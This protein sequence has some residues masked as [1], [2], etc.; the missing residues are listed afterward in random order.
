MLNLKPAVCTRPV[1]NENKYEYIQ[2][3]S[4]HKML[5]PQQVLLS[6]RITKMLPHMERAWKGDKKVWQYDG[7]CIMLDV[8]WWVYHGRCIMVFHVVSIMVLLHGTWMNMEHYTSNVVKSC[9]NWMYRGVSIQAAEIM[10]STKGASK[11]PW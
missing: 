6:A 9:S 10:W 1:T 11:V 4:E 7:G 2:L 8:S 3:M 5:G